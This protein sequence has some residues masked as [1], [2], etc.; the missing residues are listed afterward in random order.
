MARASGEVLGG[1][2]IGSGRWQ[3]HLVDRNSRGERAPPGARAPPRCTGRRPRA[4][5]RARPKG[6]S[7]RPR[8]HRARAGSPTA[9]PAG[10]RPPCRPAVASDGRADRRSEKRPSCA[11]RQELDRGVHCRH[12]RAEPPD[13]R[14]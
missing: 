10:T 11:G 12:S 2:P 7:A 14:S 8:G 1:D 13:G 5:R 3:H 9:G 6:R 4:S